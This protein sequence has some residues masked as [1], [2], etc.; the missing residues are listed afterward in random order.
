MKL[1]AAIDLLLTLIT[2]AQRVS[3]IIAQARAEGR[4]SLSEDD[5]NELTAANDDARAELE[6]AIETA[7]TEGR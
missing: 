7:R 5:I 4:E 3:T 6:A 2:Q 1:A